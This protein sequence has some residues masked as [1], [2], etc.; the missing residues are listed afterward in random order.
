MHLEITVTLKV[1]APEGSTVGQLDRWARYRAGEASVL[2]PP[3]TL[4]PWKPTVTDVG[5]RR[6]S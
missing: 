6:L 1:E 5:I 3:M 2:E 4:W